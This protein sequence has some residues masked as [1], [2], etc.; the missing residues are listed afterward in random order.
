MQQQVASEDAA[1]IVLL[2]VDT[3]PT[4]AR[5][6]AGLRPRQRND[7]Q[8]PLPDSVPRDRYVLGLVTVNLYTE[9]N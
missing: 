9:Q 1:F 7:V 5:E 6:Q 8:L 3:A 4:I 2:G